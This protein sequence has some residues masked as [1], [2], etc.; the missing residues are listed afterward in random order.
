[1]R[2]RH[3]TYKPLH[4]YKIASPEDLSDG[5]AAAPSPCSDLAPGKLIEGSFLSPF[6]P[7]SLFF[8]GDSLA[9]LLLSLSSRAIFFLPL[10]QQYGCFPLS[11]PP[12]P[13][14]FC[15]RC[16]RFVPFFVLGP[17]FGKATPLGD[18][19][20]SGFPSERP[21]GGKAV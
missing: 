8:L 4:T 10:E 6:Y 2:S 11:L 17:P 3:R 19:E 12:A 18:G 9:P 20:T 21:L 13:G 16:C 5:S 14:F 7:K 1:M 15:P